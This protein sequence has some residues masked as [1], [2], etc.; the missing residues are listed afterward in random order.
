[1]KSHGTDPF[2]TGRARDIATGKELPEKVVKYLIKA[3]KIGD[4]MYL[5][6]VN[7]RLIKGKA[8]FFDPIKKVNL[9]TGLKKTKKIRKAVSVIKERRQ[10][11]GGSFR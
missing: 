11:F 10:G 3:G 1:M 9:D 8:N 7:E 5:S 2:G 4:E 6:F